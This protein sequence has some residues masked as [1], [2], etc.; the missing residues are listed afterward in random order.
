MW[1]HVKISG[2][3][4]PSRLDHAMCSIKLPVPPVGDR[5]DTAPTNHV[6]GKVAQPLG[7][8]MSHSLGSLTE[9]SQCSSSNFQAVTVVDPEDL[10]CSN[11]SVSDA[12]SVEDQVS[13]Q[14]KGLSMSSEEKGEWDL[15]DGL[16]VFGGM[17]T[18]GVIHGDAFVLL[19]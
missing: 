15:V 1:T 7:T 2:N 3:P 16:F 9:S 11:F 5:G 10:S 18:A 17:D 19:P 14:L 8:E 13:G 6:K 4:P 12:V